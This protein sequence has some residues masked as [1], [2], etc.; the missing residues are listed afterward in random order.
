MQTCEKGLLGR[1]GCRMCFG[2]R[3]QNTT[4]PVL[5]MPLEKERLLQPSANDDNSNA[6]SDIDSDSNS[7]SDKQNVPDDITDDGLDFQK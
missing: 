2:R 7:Q 3:Q 1:T 6:D 5:L 4:H